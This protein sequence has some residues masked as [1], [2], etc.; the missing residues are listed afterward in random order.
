MT[1]FNIAITVPASALP[2]LINALPSY[3][4]ELVAVTQAEAPAAAPK[5]AA[6]PSRPKADDD[7]AKWRKHTNAF[8]V[9]SVAKS[10]YSETKAS[11]R[12][13]DVWHTLQGRGVNA[14]VE[15]VG[16]HLLSLRNMGLLENVA[17]TRGSGGYFNIVVRFI[18]EE[19]FNAEYREY[20]DA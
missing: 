11:F 13:S 5:I 20:L 2:N 9:Y 3:A 19:E 16:Q 1:K 10:L 4:A 8:E 6:Q 14:T 18:S 7:D 17:G 12:T 15:A